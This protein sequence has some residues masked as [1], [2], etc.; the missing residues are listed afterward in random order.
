[1]VTYEMTSP[2]KSLFQTAA[3]IV[4]W[5][6]WKWVLHANA[7]KRRATKE[8]LK[9]LSGGPYRNAHAIRN[10]IF[11]FKDMPQRQR[12]AQETGEKILRRSLAPSPTLIVVSR[13]RRTHTAPLEDQRIVEIRT[14]ETLRRLCNALLRVL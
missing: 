11:Y 5:L 9:F 13:M 1:M 14:R 7:P 6:G 2:S 8:I 3:E 4:K 12:H 10:A